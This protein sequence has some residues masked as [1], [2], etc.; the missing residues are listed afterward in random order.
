[1]HD[2]N[3]VS[4][5]NSLVSVYD[6]S[7][8]RET[9][10]ADTLMTAA[11]LL[12]EYFESK[13]SNYAK[14]VGV[15]KA[16]SLRRVVKDIWQ[17]S[18]YDLRK[19]VQDIIRDRYMADNLSAIIT[20]FISKKIIVW[21]HNTHISKSDSSMGY[22]TNRRYPFFSLGF[23]LGSGDFTAISDGAGMT[24]KP[25]LMQ[26]AIVDSYE[27]YFNYAKPNKWYLDLKNT[28]TVNNWLSLSHLFR[29]TGVKYSRYQFSNTNLLADFDAII[30]IK[31]STPSHLIFK[32]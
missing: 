18:M 12:V 10:L 14:L 13:Y 8:N 3:L 28:K 1:L 29:F 16:D 21:A 9:Y 25:C 17:Y 20:E 11:D 19:T 32:P 7:T 26:S 30:F 2:K 15:Q 4:Y 24:I 22:L 27:S 31:K 5:L 6:K 23:S